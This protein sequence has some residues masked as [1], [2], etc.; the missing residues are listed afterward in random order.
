MN[1]EEADILYDLLQDM[2]AFD[3][4][5]LCSFFKLSRGGSKDNLIIRIIES[6]YELNEIVPY[7]GF[8]SLISDIE[9]AFNKS[10]FSEILE[11]A[12]IAHSGKKHSLVL[13]VVENNLIT[14]KKL[15][16]FVWMEDLRNLYYNR[17]GKISTK[18]EPETIHDI[19]VSYYLTDGNTIND[20]DKKTGLIKEY[21]PEDVKKFAF[22]LMPFKE[23]LTKIYYNIIKPVV[24]SQ[25]YYCK[26]ADDFFT[27]NKIMDDIEKA[28]RSS[29]FIIADLTDKNPNVFYEVGMSHILEKKVI[30]LTQ[31]LED[32]PFDLRHWR[33]I[34]YDPS[35][36]GQKKLAKKLVKTIET[37]LIQ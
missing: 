15:L 2:S 21:P 29:A 35:E 27:T 10:F 17:Y 19:L 37:I 33:H 30:L 26:R 1:D 24:E 28:I 4:R 8:V 36:R 13:R 23:D 3:L 9:Y 14:P 18:S 22:I 20:E 5:Y 16:T 6:D 25:N 11:N 34:R 32:V 31:S 12:G 7:A